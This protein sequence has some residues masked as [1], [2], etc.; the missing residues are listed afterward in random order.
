M[1][2]G[3]IVVVEPVVDQGRPECS[4][5]SAAPARRISRTRTANYV[6][7]YFDSET[8]PL[9]ISDK[10]QRFL[11]VANEIRDESPRA[12]YMCEFFLLLDLLIWL[13]LR[14]FLEFFLVEVCLG[15][16]HAFAKAHE[17]DPSSAIRGVRQLKTAL[18]S[19]LERTPVYNILPLGSGG[20]QHAIMQFPEIKATIAALRKIRGLPWPNNHYS[21]GDD[22]MDLLDWLQC[23]FRF[24]KGNVNNQ[25]EHL[26][27]LLANIHIR[28]FSRPEPL[29]ELDDRAVN[30][31]MT[32]LLKNYKAWCKF[33]GRPS[34]L[35]YDIPFSHVYFFII[36]YERGL[37][38]NFLHICG[39]LSQLQNLRLAMLLLFRLPTVHQ[40]VQQYKLLYI[41]LYLLIWG[42]ASNLRFMPECLCYIFHHMAY[43]LVSHLSG[44]VSFKTGESFTP[45]YG[46]GK[47]DFLTQVITP[48]YNVVYKKLN[49]TNI[50]GRLIVFNWDGQCVQAWQTWQTFS[51][52][53]Q[54]ASIRNRSSMMTTCPMDDQKP[55]WL[56]KTNFV[57]IRSFWQLFRSFDRMWAFLLLALQAMI[58]MAWHGVQSPFD[59]LDAAILKDIMS[60]FITSSVINFLRGN[61]IVNVALHVLYS[62]F[63]GYCSSQLSQFSDNYYLV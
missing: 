21:S 39:T 48:I 34:N 33:L 32:R 63:G 17:I 20:A 59:V 31:L 42:E 55:I 15:R 62:S 8:L 46:Q 30:E 19:Q 53:F 14:F 10:I 11:R 28:Q 57:E 9:G 23:W 40:E 22:D 61:F 24:Q 41:A 13:W 58:V 49:Q 54:R 35:W 25:R 29:S 27:L 51:P 6:P 7:N 16:F 60:I 3:E 26:I 37:T 56:G 52:H 2:L 47:G 45:T 12:S 1:E 50:L 18:I 5:P 36:F 44:A 43:E 4:S 38:A